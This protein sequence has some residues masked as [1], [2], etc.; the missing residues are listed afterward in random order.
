MQDRRPQAAISSPCPSR[1]MGIVPRIP[2][3]CF[4]LSASVIG[5]SMKPGATQLTVML[6]LATSAASALVMPMSPAFEAA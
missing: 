3:R 2:S 4:S 6:R 5:D 1:A